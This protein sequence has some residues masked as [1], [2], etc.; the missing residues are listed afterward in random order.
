[1]FDLRDA[2]VFQFLRNKYDR[3]SI[4]PMETL[5]R[6]NTNFSIRL[7]ES[8][9]LLADEA[10]AAPEYRFLKYYQ[11][12]VREYM[13]EIAGGRID[14]RGLLLYWTMG[15]GKSIG[16]I[17]IAMDLIAQGRQV[18]ML[19]TKSLQGNMREAIVKYVR[20]RTA[21]EP[22]YFLGRLDA[23]DLDRWID[24]N[25]SF[26]SMNASNMLTQMARASTGAGR[27]SSLDRK[28]G[29]IVAAASLNGKVLIVDEAHN[30]F[31]AI[32]NGSA[33]ALGVYNMVM[34]SRDCRCVFL[35]GTPIGNDPFELTACFNM[36]G[37]RRPGVA[38]FPEDYKEFRQHFVARDSGRLINRGKFQNR[39]MG[40]I[41]YVR[42]DTRWKD[43]G[44]AEST[45]EFPDATPIQVV[46]VPMGA[47]QYVRYQLARDKEREEASRFRGPV[48]P[49]ASM[50]KPRSSASS[51]YRVNS[52]M[53]SNY[54]A[55][56]EF[57]DV[58]DVTKLPPIVSPK[59]DAILA[60]INDSEGLG[61]V[62]SQ[63]TGIGGLA[64]LSRYLIEHGWEVVTV[65]TSDAAPGVFAEDLAIVEAME[66]A[67]TEAETFDERSGAFEAEL[68][69]PD[70]YLAAI[71]AEFESSAD[72]PDTSGDF[73]GGGRNIVDYIV[74]AGLDVHSAPPHD[75]VAIEHRSISGGSFD[76][77]IIEPPVLRLPT[78]TGAELR[79]EAV[80]RG[81]NT[82]LSGFII[83]GEPHDQHNE[84]ALGRRRRFAI[85]SGNVLPVDRDKIKDRYN[86]D[87]NKEG[88]DID[89]LLIS[90]TGA[91]G[92][93][94]KNVRHEH[95]VEPYWV[96]GRI[97]QV[98]ARGIRANSHIAL[99]PEKRNVATYVYLAVSPHKQFDAAGIAIN[100]D[101]SPLDPAT[102]PPG[103]EAR[104]TD[105]EI[106]EEALA[107]H[108]GND[109]FNTAL[110]EVSIECSMIE[111]ATCRTCAPT[112]EPLYTA[113][114]RRDIA[115]ADPCAAAQSSEV[116][117]APIEYEG[118]TYYYR[119]SPD[120][121]YGWT[122][123]QPAPDLGGFRA[124]PENDP[125]FEK[126]AAAIDA[127]APSTAVASQ[128]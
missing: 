25:F 62:Y 104:S 20:L 105:E 28:L 11:N 65:G 19:L 42:H 57:K 55:P 114:F 61:L 91:E 115:A 95:I 84:A 9:K 100:P 112:D 22:D 1:M 106:Y 124:L 101:G 7:A 102:L 37:S 21:A 58:T 119:A 49:A 5:N 44:I 3:M 47:E 30:L 6:A 67:E 94:L 60:R 76:D 82:S 64:S 23:A 51:S 50:T 39:I 38:I 118:T 34:S 68:I 31:R 96:H 73:I 83:G 32:T 127:A 121:V 29:D 33:N 72:D 46:R 10:A 108:L 120:S 71:E 117:A 90:S 107:R 93:D 123:Y 103:E 128:S 125:R 27:G 16:A 97:E 14:S 12:I 8:L 13:A 86:A 80:E 113:N 48:A 56:V 15:L 79:D 109:S 35:T 45:S 17:G 85:I 81:S 4:D 74:G 24:R 111:D 92:L 70:E 66:A 98:R 77:P 52:R 53:L 87:E 59:Y 75:R 36:L 99:P 116:E 54:A 110:Q 41:S 88:G 89:L 69:D 26:V 126:I 2:S 122:V 43:D 18:I 78:V 63:F 40:L